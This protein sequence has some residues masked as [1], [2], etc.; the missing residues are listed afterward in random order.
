MT[1][2][3]PLPSTSVPSVRG[4][5]AHSNGER[6]PRR[7]RGERGERARACGGKGRGCDVARAR[8]HPRVPVP[9]ARGV[10]AEALLGRRALGRTR[11]QSAQQLGVAPVGARRRAGARWISTAWMQ[12]AVPAAAAGAGEGW[13][14]GK[15]A[16][17]LVCV[18]CPRQGWSAQGAGAHVRV[19]AGLLFFL[20]SL[21]CACARLT[22]S[23]PPRCAGVCVRACVCGVQTKLYEAGH[24]FSFS[25]AKFYTDGGANQTPGAALGKQD[26]RQRAART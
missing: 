15:S 16:F 23:F 22:C 10:C 11:L 9:T 1:R 14:V 6:K 19:L 5:R 20:R 4:P 25:S 7:K 13:A 24:A 18:F 21:A 2:A 8:L 26:V 12:L 3:V 17:G